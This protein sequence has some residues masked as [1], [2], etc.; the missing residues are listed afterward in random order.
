MWTGRIEGESEPPKF[1]A[2][3]IARC[4]AIERQNAASLVRFE[5]ACAPK[6]RGIAVDVRLVSRP[7]RTVSTSADWVAERVGFEPSVRLS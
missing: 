1:A 3:T 5:Q 2:E 4:W 7:D 6:T